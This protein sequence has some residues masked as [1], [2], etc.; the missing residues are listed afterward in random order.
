M[1]IINIKKCLFQSAMLPGKTSVLNK[2]TKKGNFL[3]SSLSTIEID[4]DIII[5]EYITINHKFIFLILEDKIDTK[6]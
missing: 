1:E 6:D 2:L 5:Y 4:K 3:E